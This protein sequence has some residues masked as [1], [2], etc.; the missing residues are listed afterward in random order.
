MSTSATY[1]E[2]FIALIII[3]SASCYYVNDLGF[4]EHSTW[5]RFTYMFS[6]ANIIHL[7]L[8]WLAFYVLAEYVKLTPFLFTPY[9]IAVLATFGSEMSLPTVGLSGVC[10]AMLGTSCYYAE[11]TSRWRIIIAFIFSNGFMLIGG[12]INVILHTLCFVYSIITS[13]IY[14]RITGERYV[15]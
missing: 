14:E 4:T 3:I 15:Q 11:G 5:Q 1:R 6:H 13:Y 2:V 10:Y 7:T 9:I 8:N 12:H